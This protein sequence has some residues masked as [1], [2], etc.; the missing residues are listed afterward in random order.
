MIISGIREKLFYMGFDMIQQNVVIKHG[1]F[2]L[3]KRFLE[4]CKKNQMSTKRQRRKQTLHHFN[5]KIHIKFESRNNIM[6]NQLKTSWKT[7]TF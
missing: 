3:S 2:L 7:E 4:E 1:E 5:V 6:E